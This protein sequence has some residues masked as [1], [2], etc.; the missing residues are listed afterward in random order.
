MPDMPD[1]PLRPDVGPPN[2]E[3]ANPVP[4][5]T[6]PPDLGPQPL[7]LTVAV[8]AAR[9]AA[10]LG[11]PERV[12]AHPALAAAV[13]AALTEARRAI[14]PAAVCSVVAPSEAPLPPPDIEAD[15]EAG[16]QAQADWTAV[17][18]VVPFVATIGPSLEEAAL[19]AIKAGKPLQAMALDAAASAASL[20]LVDSLVHHLAAG[21]AAAVG[22]EPTAL[23]FPGDEG[24]GLENLRRVLDLLPAPA[25]AVIGVVVRDSGLL[26]PLKSVA[27]IIGLSRS[28]RLAGRG[29]AGRAGRA[30]RS[31]E[32]SDLGRRA[33][34]RCPVRERCSFRH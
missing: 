18:W 4:A 9:V 5:T 21:P 2:S 3:P 1:K 19:A 17:D 22:L 7:A 15:V 31:G 30:N 14:R 12:V 33:C 20:T 10:C 11:P 8:D 16:V 34:G 6:A 29:R 24:F 27:G 26:W 13:E 28:G 32:V 23:A 25:V